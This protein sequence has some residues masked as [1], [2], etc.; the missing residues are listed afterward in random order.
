[1]THWI[2]PAQ[3]SNRIRVGVFMG[4]RSIECEVSFNS[5][6]TICDHLDSSRYDIYP[7]FQTFDGKLYLL[8][9]KFLHRGKIADFIHRLDDEATLLR[10]DELKTMINFVYI[11]VHGRY[12]ED[13]TLQGMLEVLGIPYLGTK[14]LGS[15]LSMNKGMQ[16]MMLEHHEI[17]VPRGILLP[18]YKADTLTGEEIM[19]QLSESG[20][21]FP[22]IVKPAHEGSSLGVCVVEHENDLQQAVYHAATIDPRHHQAV[23]IEEKVIG[24]EFVSVLLEDA[25]GRDKNSQSG[26]RALSVTEVVTEQ[27]TDFFDYE[28]KYMPGRAAKITPARCSQQA[29]QDIVSACTKTA[30]ILSLAGTVRV[31]GFLTADGRVVIIDVNPLT[32]MAPATFLFHQAAEAGMG[33]ADLINRLIDT[34]LK[35]YGMNVL[36]EHGSHEYKQQAAAQCRVAVL[37]GGDSHEREI[38]LESGRNVCYK[39]SPQKYEV[40]PIFVNEKMELFKLD[41]TLLLQN[42]TREIAHRVEPEQKL[43][44]ADLPAVCDFVFIALHGG[45]GENGSVQGALEMLGLPYNGSGVLTSSLCLDKFRTNT[46]LRDQGFDVPMSTVVERACWHDEKKLQVLDEIEGKFTYPLIIKPHNDGCSVLVTKAANRLQ[47]IEA[48]EMIFATEKD[49]A[50]I[51]EYI[52]GMELTCGVYGNAVPTVLPASWSVSKGSVLSIEEKF[53]P[54]EGENQTPAPLSLAAE[55]LVQ[56]VLGSVYSLLGCAGYVRIDCFYQTAEQ[57]PT[58]QERVVILEINTLPA[59]TPATCL[60]HQAAEV[61]IK[62]MDFIDMIVQMGFEQHQCYEKLSGQVSLDVMQ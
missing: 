6:R 36:I 10:W 24:M 59:L 9:W 28:Q 37:L 38:S 29:Y 23:L 50:L 11:A 33:H 52:Q 7:I 8:P 58:K 53:L 48:V 22:L 30:E 19:M 31:D 62:P 3:T 49:V 25:L 21:S 27:G 1:M 35:A 13:G 16:K 44:W 26:W 2:K 5:G 12:A 60:F 18:A 46:F 15:A 39:L 17:S 20:L 32:G 57:S 45:R 41:Q 47:L 54:G 55:K 4:G 56:Q 14:V 51:E 42:S 34:S 43:A 40:I 61:N